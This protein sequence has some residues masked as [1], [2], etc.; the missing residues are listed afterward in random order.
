MKADS[1]A[2]LNWLNLLHQQGKLRALDLALSRY[3]A[4]AAPESDPCVL[5]AIALTSERNGHGDVCLD[6]IGAL[7]HLELAAG[8]DAPA[9][10]S[11]LQML[12]SVSPED[13][14]A[15]LSQSAAIQRLASDG[16]SDQPEK[17]TAPLVL[18]GSSER[19]ILYLRRY[20]NYEQQ[21]RTALM[22]RI[23]HCYDLPEAPMAALLNSLFPPSADTAQPDW[24]KIACAL[25]ARRGFA[26]ITG[27][28]GTG[29]TTTVVRLLALLQA[30]A[31]QQ[32]QPVLRIALAAPTGKAAARL[33][34]SI[35]AQVANLP[36]AALSHTPE[37]L[38]DAIP[39]EVT[40][41]HRLLG[42]IPDSRRFR[43]HRSQQLPVD[44]VVV[45]EASMVDLEMLAALVD[46]LKPSARLIL[47][48]DKDQLA[49]VEAGAILGDLCQLASLGRYQDETAQWL[50]DVT[51][52]SL[53]ARYLS[54]IGRPLDQAITMLRQSHRFSEQGGIG[55][56]A[57]LVN[58]GQL[59]GQPVEDRLKALDQLFTEQQG[60]IDRLSVSHA[61]DASLAQLITQGYRTYLQ[62]IQ[63]SRPALA[64]GQA[65]H[66]LWAAQVL[67]THTGF[68]L[69]CAVREGS[70]GVEQL[71]L[72]ITRTLAEAGL[73]EGSDALWYEGRPVLI[74]RNDYSLR[75]M[76]GDIG[77]A[78]MRPVENPDGSIT[79][80]L[81]V[82]FPAVDGSVRWVMPSRLQALETVFAMT[83]HKSQGSEF[84]HTAL[85]LPDQPNPV[86]TQELIYTGITRSRQRFTL[87]HS[88]DSVLR[89]AL[90]K[91]VTRLSGLHL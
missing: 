77:I 55:A 16:Q 36:L 64:A 84:S 31:L 20:W 10:A 79:S 82:V 66:D 59:Y 88:R 8:P 52:Y 37:Q 51:G 86:L 17:A 14:W 45:D 29:K 74:T 70:W 41:L 9:L 2:S 63:Q 5:L 44:L 78:L 85:V 80:A 39:T 3:I 25:S 69:L 11:I 19:P 53:D 81:R 60:Q 57:R 91:R 89:H 34:A 50:T 47:L 1:E 68:Q 62:Q 28:P 71:N 43:H 26:V 13:W 46:A 76:N 58:D 30:L 72:W 4:E 21:V 38:A 7:T 49:S 42:P 6:L 54:E 48:G 27:G 23:D 33:N 35:A 73:L 18:S 90:E 65:A 32:E 22:Q 15:R 87:I 67:E 56:L 75:L 61:A 12:R 83:V 40:T 24:Q